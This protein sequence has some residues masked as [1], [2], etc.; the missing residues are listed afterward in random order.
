M[1]FVGI[2]STSNFH[3][4]E[5]CLNKINKHIIIHW[6]GKYIGLINLIDSE[7]RIYEINQ[8]DISQNLVYHLKSLKKI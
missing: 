2:D 6:Q 3:G 8:P 7:A 4:Q 1:Y 5:S